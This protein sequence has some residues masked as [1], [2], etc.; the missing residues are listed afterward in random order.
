MSLPWHR[1]I[2]SQVM[3]L[4]EKDALPHAIMLSGGR[5]LGANTLAR[6]LALLVLCE[7]PVNLSACGQCK[8]CHLMEAGSHNDF[9]QLSP[10][11][12]GK[13]IKVE[14]VRNVVGFITESS[15][16]GGHKVAIIDPV[17]GL[18]MSGSNALLKTL[19]EPAGDTVIFLVT[20]RQDAVLPTI[21][22]RCQIL[23]VKPPVESEALEWLISVEPSLTKDRAL[24]Y[25]KLTHN[26]PLT[27]QRYAEQ[28]AWEQQ[29]QILQ[30]F[31]KVLKKQISVS[32]FSE[33]LVGEGLADRLE[34]MLQWVEQMIRFKSLDDDSVFS[35]KE[36]VAMLR[37]LA[38]KNSMESLFQ[39]REKHLEQIRL[40]RGTTNP[41]PALLFEFL[42]IAWLGCM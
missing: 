1:D 3:T 34:W 17:E 18:N 12:E 6:E 35:H 16:R 13:Q 2:L 20:D 21:R 19:E 5:G 42:V 29:L 7:S 24:E 22:S 31:P 10:E 38:E 26:S 39:L 8:A 15:M 11:E 27:A 4:H 14:A 41:N 23:T 40:L 30:E 25:L 32:Q 36:S 37:Y 28:Q 33:K 9:V